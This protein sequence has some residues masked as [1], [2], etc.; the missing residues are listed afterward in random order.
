MG[1]HNKSSIVNQ[2]MKDG[3]MCR[4]VVA[5]M[6]ALIR[7]ELKQIC[8][9][10][11]KSL[12]KNKSLLAIESFKWSET[13][14]DLKINAPTLFSLLHTCTGS[15]NCITSPTC[16]K[17]QE[18]AITFCAGILLRSYSERGNLVQRLMSVLLYASHA[19]KQV[20]ID[21]DF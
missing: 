15:A 1:R 6:G 5:K 20:S 3:F 18:I 4:R 13:A 17:K 8:S 21:G 19:P 10:E 12:F 11:K 7:R 9:D 14:A 16:S 2:V